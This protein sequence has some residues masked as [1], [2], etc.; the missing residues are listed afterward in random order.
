MQGLDS[1]FGSSSGRECT[2]KTHGLE[3]LFNIFESLLADNDVAANQQGNAL[4]ASFIAL[5]GLYFDILIFL[6][7][8][9]PYEYR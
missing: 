9:V 4:Q 3:T 8:F 5:L 7:N 1:G 2:V 6:C